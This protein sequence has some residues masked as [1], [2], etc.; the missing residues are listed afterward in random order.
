M[1][2]RA[3]ARPTDGA[4]S[5]ATE[6]FFKTFA[7]PIVFVLIALGFHFFLRGH[8]APGGGFIAGLIV[9]VAALLAR[10]ARD[11]RLLRIRAETLV[12]V[13]LLIALATGVA[14]MIWDGSFLQ[15]DYG[16]LTW[17][18]IGEFEWATAVAF[19]VG[20]FLVVIGTTITIIDL[21]ADER[22]LLELGP[23]G[24]RGDDTPEAP[25]D[26]VSDDDVE[27]GDADG[28]GADRTTVRT[29]ERSEGGAG[30]YGPG[31]PGDRGRADR[32]LGDGRTRE[33]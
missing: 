1:S 14:P 12:P 15:S 23:S 3:N 30:E 25:L 28:D 8:N 7:T 20:V 26:A 22:N 24:M 27:D 10:M 18:W 4:R 19:D 32:D 5:D 21:L 11:L 13:G 31:D 6:V 16:Y 2:D 33:G 29:D 9:A 17:P